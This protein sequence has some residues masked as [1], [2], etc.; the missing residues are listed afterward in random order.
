MNLKNTELEQLLEDF[1]TKNI[2]IQEIIKH[3][4]DENNKLW[5]ENK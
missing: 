3:L 5:E 2:H 1:N 4:Q